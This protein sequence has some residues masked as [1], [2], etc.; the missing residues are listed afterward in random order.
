MQFCK[1]VELERA[2]MK[3]ALKSAIEFLNFIGDAQ[4]SRPLNLCM[5]REFEQSGKL[6]KRDYSPLALRD[7][8]TSFL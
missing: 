3:L 2:K 1:Y 4:I 8:V 7:H 6:F 5:T